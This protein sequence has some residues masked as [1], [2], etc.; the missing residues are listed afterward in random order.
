MK[1]GSN[2][3]YLKYRDR[4]YSFIFG[5]VNDPNITDDI[6]Q[7]IFLKIHTKIDTLKDHEKLESWIYQITRNAI[8][9]Y[10][11]TNKKLDELPDSYTEPVPDSDPKE[12]EEISSWLRPM[13]ENLPDKYRETLL[14]SEIKGISQKEIA[15]KI[16]LSLP[17][18]K[19]RIQ[20][21]RSLVKKTLLKCCHFEFDR[22]GRVLDYKEKSDT[23]THC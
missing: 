22:R 6:L 2:Y 1:N 5:R 20:R 4:L 7:N 8:I 11:R 9:D 16:G 18:T 23:C 3:L 21:G 19:S 10:Y 13:I 17:G 15:K 14:L 12:R